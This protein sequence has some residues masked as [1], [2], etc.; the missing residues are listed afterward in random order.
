MAVVSPHPTGWT[1]GTL[2]FKDPYPR[3]QKHRICLLISPLPQW[4]PPWSP[5]SLAGQLPGCRESPG[6][7]LASSF[8]LFH[9]HHLLSPSTS[10]HLTHREPSP[11]PRRPFHQLFRPW[12]LSP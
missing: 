8:P 6:L 7:S 1:G 2:P 12:P 9:L 11:R 5:F 4:S 10:L 3:L